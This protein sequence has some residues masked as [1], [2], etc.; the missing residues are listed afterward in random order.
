MWTLV[1]SLCVVFRAKKMERHIRLV[2]H[3][4]AASKPSLFAPNASSFW[5][6]LKNLT[7]PGQI[8]PIFPRTLP[9]FE[10]ITRASADLVAHHFF[11]NRRTSA[12]FFSGNINHGFVN[13]WRT[14]RVPER[15]SMYRCDPTCLLM[16][17]CSR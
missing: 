7:I 3:D 4:P 1:A 10:T 8:L 15:M 5:A 13:E 6:K 9:F 16:I 17:E 12:L 11:L 2:A 14:G